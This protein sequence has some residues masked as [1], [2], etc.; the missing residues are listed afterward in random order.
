MTPKY[1]FQR[2]SLFLLIL[3]FVNF[4]QAQQSP[5]FTIAFGSCNRT[6]LP[7]NLWDDIYNSQPNLFIWGGDNVYADTDNMKK[8]AAFYK[9]LKEQP[10]YAKIH[11]EIP[12]IGTWDDHDYGMNDGGVHF[13]AK[14]DS[15]SV[16]LDFM[17]VAKDS[18]R[19]KQAGVYWAH[20]YKTADL[21]IKVLVLDTRYFRSDLTP[22]NETSKRNKPNPY[23]QGTMLGNAQW[24]WLENELQDAAPDLTLLVSSVQFLSNEHGFECWGNFPHEVDKLEQMLVNSVSQNVVILS[25]DRHISEISKKQIPGLSYPLI[26]FTSSGLTHA[27]T[28]FKGEPNPYRTTKVVAEESFGLLEFYASER[29]LV[30]KMIIDGGLTA[31]ALEMHF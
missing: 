20:H 15:Q 9:E 10:G 24:E 18:P 14:V 27:Y 3:M 21:Y 31:D 26:D 6:D 25:G 29:K 17:G 2:A 19:R 13:N 16:F 30:M 11:S 12:I 5:G 1:F 7:N 4:L 28:K 22:D 8:L 23:G